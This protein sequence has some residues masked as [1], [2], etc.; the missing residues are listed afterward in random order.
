MEFAMISRRWNF[1]VLCASLT[2]IL[3]LSACAGT[4]RTVDYSELDIQ[5]LQSLMVDGQLDSERL[6]R[7]YLDRIDALDAN[8]PMLNSIIEVN[9]D[10]V[11]IA[12]ALDRERSTTGSRGPMHGIPV[13]L[14]ANI[15]TADRMQTTAGSLALAG[16]I[17]S[18]DAFFVQRLRE[19]GAI[20]LAK[21]NLSEWA[22]FRSTKSSSGWSSVGGQTRNPY[23]TRRN[24]CGSSSGSGVAVAAGLTSV[25]VGTETDGSVVCPSSINGI[26]GVKP[27]LGLV[28]R[29]GIIP[30]AHSQDTAGPMGRTVRDAAILLNAMT[31]R[32][33]DDPLAGE[34]PA[35]N[36]DFVVG[37]DVNALRGARIGVINYDGKGDDARI[38]A[39][40]DQSVE[41]MRKLGA[42][43]VSGIDMSTDELG[44]AEFEVLLYE[45]K[46]DLNKYLSN[47][48]APVKSLAD[49]IAF[50]EENAAMVM[51][52]FKQELM[53]MA[54][55]K[56][57]LTDAAYLDALA[58][59]KRV[60]QSAI[61]NAL[62][63]HNLDALI[64]PTDGLAWM[65]DHIN[66]DSY[67]N[68]SSSSF[69]AVSGYPSIT[70]PA[71][72]VAGLPA[73]ISFI[74]GRYRDAQ[75]IA[76]AYAYEQASRMRRPPEL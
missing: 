70:V 67:P 37:L 50:N 75:I 46:S 62:E 36:P 1:S 52:I 28:G 24:P 54:Q 32:D 60:M 20:I 6:V 29:S 30:I 66:G 22:N 31:G 25:A 16:H 18:K 3:I 39:I 13:V 56:G 43:I 4:G 14:K 2:F 26:V 71:G 48:G 53:E 42:E 12:R 9:P 10:A 65:T 21:A 61:D 33:P 5:S 76:Y 68:I 7:F 38:D 63:Q 23:D 17:A 34:Y 59:S 58:T 64:A 73:G 8:G 69:A 51:P 44:D 35:S 19:A 11:E 74:G 27:S 47:S 15:D 40:F 45:F 57:P 72:N 41:A 49:I 55:E